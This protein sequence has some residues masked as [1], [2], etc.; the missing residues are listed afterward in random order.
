MIDIA[1]HMMHLIE[2]RGWQAFIV[3]GFVR[4]FV[5]GIDSKDIDIE[6]FGPQSVDEL[7]VF[8]CKHFNDVKFVGK[9]FGVFKV[10]VDGV[11][12]DISLPRTE[13]KSGIG[14][15]G[16]D[17]IPNGNITPRLAASR[18]DFTFN[19]LMMDS[20]GNVVDFFNGVEHLKSKRLVHTSESFRDDPL[21]V[22]R[23]FQFCG[24]FNLVA[25]ADTVSMSRSLLSEFDTLPVDRLWVEFE[26]WATK[27]V[28]P[29][30]GLVFLLR[31]GWLDKF[32]QLSCMIGVKQSQ[33]FHAE[34]SVWQHT[35]M[36]CDHAAKIAKRE[37]LSSEDTLVLLLAALLHDTGKAITTDEDTKA[38]KHSL[39][40]ERLARSFLESIRAPH[41]V[42]DKV[43]S[44]VVEHM[45][46]PTTEAGVMRLSNRLK[47]S[48]KMLSLLMKADTLGRKS[49][50]IGALKSLDRINKMVM[51]ADSLSVAEEKPQPILM[52]RH[53]IN[54]GMKPG[55]EFGVILSAAFDAQMNQEFNTLEGAL[56]WL[57][58]RIN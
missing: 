6:V 52:G 57:Q 29:S 38:P 25:D 35:K 17:V 49:T 24:R 41:D 12:F 32:P 42:I 44:L 39:E 14:H 5:L 43:C 11:D 13:S 4:D 21:R 40:S 30:R 8:L 2:S 55:K 26:T 9:S 37:Q 51:I 20:G 31:S 27:S 36:V 47:T 22:M 53:L 16:F 19:A 15:K 54:L 23:G 7:Q 56:Q 18:R 48:V 28:S 50:I 10:R 46:I 1:F 33:E 3:G 34:G 58:S 45:S